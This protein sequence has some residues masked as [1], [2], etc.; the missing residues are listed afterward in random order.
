M[1][2]KRISYWLLAGIVIAVILL[3]TQPEAQEPP[4]TLRDYPEIKQ[5]GILRAVTEYNAI[6]YHVSGDTIQG[7]DYELLHTF[8]K[9][10]GLRLKI[11][12]EMS[13]DK[14]LQ[15]ISDGK[16]DILA[17][18]TIITTRSKHSLLFT[19]TLQLSKQVLVQRKKEEGKDSMYI[20]SQLDLAHKTL[21]VIK[22]SPTLLRIHNLME[23]IADTIY[24]KQVTQYG[25]EQL[26]AMV[27]EGD[28]DYAVCD[29]HIA[30]ASIKDFPNLDINTDISFTQFYAWGVGKYAP[31]LLDSLNS[32]LD[33]YTE[34][35]EYKQ[36]YNKYFN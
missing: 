2:R 20:K 21:H 18:G 8:A 27:A 34:S 17:T 5:S 29:E 13:F 36:L 12:P 9:E 22:H 28:I 19:H 33:T 4:A 14:R 3:C 24:V 11:I 15:M 26:L 16:C 30:K 32:W 1:P 7:F 10:K 25:P 6:S 31:I 35:K 23:E